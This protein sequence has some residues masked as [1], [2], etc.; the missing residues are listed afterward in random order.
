MKKFVLILSLLFLSCAQNL[1]REITQENSEIQT[2][3]NNLLKE[4]E[5]D[6]L[7]LLEDG[8]Q[9]GLTFYYLNKTRL[10]LM[11]KMDKF[12]FNEKPDRLTLILELNQERSRL[13]RSS[14]P[15][16][17]IIQNLDAQIAELKKKME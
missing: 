16:N 9:D 5:H 2:S 6:M 7:T 10:S 13:L 11:D 15:S 3:M 1:D 17:P 8:E 12:S 4:I 14:S